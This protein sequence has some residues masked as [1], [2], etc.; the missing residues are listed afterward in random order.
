MNWVEALLLGILQ[1]LTEFLPVSSSGH[2]EI[3]QAILGT[4]GEENLTFAIIVHAATV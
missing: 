2:L 1:G 4:A 3:G